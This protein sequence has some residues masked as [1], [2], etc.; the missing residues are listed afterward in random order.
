MVFS[1]QLSLPCLCAS[2]H[3]L[4]RTIIVT[5]ADDINYKHGSIYK[6]GSLYEHGSLSLSLS[7][8]DKYMPT[9]LTWSAEG[10]IKLSLISEVIA[11]N[12]HKSDG[13]EL[14]CTNMVTQ[15]QC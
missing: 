7:L 1:H 5:Y 4:V 3:N 10:K 11:K 9:L 15:P 14:R 6:H 2:C 8:D 13:D 12:H